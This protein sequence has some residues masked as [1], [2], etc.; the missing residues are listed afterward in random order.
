VYGVYKGRLGTQFASI[1][2]RRDAAVP[3]NTTSGFMRVEALD[4][5]EGFD[6][7]FKPVLYADDTDTMTNQFDF[8]WPYYS[9][10]PPG[11]RYTEWADL[12][13]HFDNGN[14]FNAYED[15]VQNLIMGYDS[16]GVQHKNIKQLPLDG[17]VRSGY[18]IKP[19]GHGGRSNGATIIGDD[20]YWTG[21]CKDPLN[22]HDAVWEELVDYDKLALYLQQHPGCLL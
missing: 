11:V 16:E 6:P 15:T 5:G 7:A 1:I 19:D 12:K 17:S 13:P 8:I 3:K 14:A 4:F 21:T 18:W 9:P 20:S 2:V 22:Y 10:L